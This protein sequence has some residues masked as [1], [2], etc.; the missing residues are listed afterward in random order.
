MRVGPFFKWFG[1]KWSAAGKYPA[2]KHATIVEPFAGSAGYACFHAHMH[3]VILYE[4][5]PQIRSLWHWLLEARPYEVREIPVDLEPGT[6]IRTLGL[7]YGQELLLKHWQR[8]NT[9]G[10]S[11]KVSPWGSKP[12]QWTDS[13]RRRIADELGWIRRWK[14]RGEWD[15]HI[16]GDSTWFID[17]PY[18]FNFQYG[19]KNFDYGNLAACV[20]KLESLES[21][22]I[23]CEAIGPKGERPNWLPFQES[24]EQVTSRR[25]KQ[26]SKELV[27]VR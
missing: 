27:Y 15:G 21:Q 5:N 20:S 12:G 17:P 11:W 24:H 8:T 4:R 9:I 13:T 16:L 25:K 2:P 14:I 1:S 26:R 3:D 6:D 22:V 23:V 7:S 10:P 18:Q 19:V